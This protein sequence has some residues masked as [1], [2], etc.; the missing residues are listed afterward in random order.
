ML[1]IINIVRYEL[2]TYRRIHHRSAVSVLSAIEICNI[3][4]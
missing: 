2:S 1:L 4:T 3:I